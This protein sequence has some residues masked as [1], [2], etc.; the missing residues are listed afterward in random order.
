MEN[1]RGN[2]LNNDKARQANRTS[3]FDDES[4][5]SLTRVADAQLGVVCYVMQDKAVSCINL[6]LSVSTAAGGSGP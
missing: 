4:Q 5:K 2:D 3:Y 6:S 1:G